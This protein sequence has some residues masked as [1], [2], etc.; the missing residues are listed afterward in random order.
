MYDKIDLSVAKKNNENKGKNMD[1]NLM[2]VG[3]EIN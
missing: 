1:F 2:V 3:T